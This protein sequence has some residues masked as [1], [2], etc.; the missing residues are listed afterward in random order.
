MVPA[1]VFETRLQKLRKSL[2]RQGLDGVV[3][4]PGPNMRY[5]TSVQS[6][7]LERP[8]L[9]FIPTDGEAHLV[10]PNIEAGP[11]ARSPVQITIHAWDDAGGPS[12]AFGSLRREVSLGGRWGCEGRVPFGYLTQ[13]TGQEAGPRAGRPLPGVD[14]GGQGRRRD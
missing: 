1:S 6:Q 8:F 14:T 10:A 4:A 13:I 11:Y 9:L 2:K 5:Y 3:L 12:G 7:I